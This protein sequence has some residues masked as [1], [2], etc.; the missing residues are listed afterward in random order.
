MAKKKAG[1]PKMQAAAEPTVRH[2]RIELPDDVY[3]RLKAVAK[4]STLPIA[5]YIRLAVV[6]RIE[7]DEKKA[8][9][10]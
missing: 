10:S 7:A 6:E 3:E 5:A 4:R 9:R 8:T 1:S 2:A